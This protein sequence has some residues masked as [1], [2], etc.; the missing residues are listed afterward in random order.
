M[1][2]I[3][4]LVLWPKKLASTCKHFQ[5]HA[6]LQILLVISVVLGG[7]SQQDEAIT[8]VE[9]PP[10]AV[11]VSSVS[12][13]N[14]FHKVSYVGTVHS[15]REVK[16]I[17]QIP[18]TVT[19]L[20]AEGSTI[21]NGQVLARIAARETE[22]RATRV[23]AEAQRATTERDFLCKTFD[24]D[25]R[26][27]AAGVISKTK[28]DLS[29]KACDSANAAL[30][31]ALAAVREARVGTSKTLEAAPF[32]GHVLRWLVESGQNVMP[33]TPLLL[34]G[35]HSLELRVQ[36]AERDISKGVGPGSSALVQVRGN[37]TK[38]SI[39]EVAPM[40]TGPSRSVEVR[41]HFTGDMPASL[42]HGMS[43]RVDLVLAEAADTLAIPES[44]LWTSGGKTSVFLIDGDL[45]RQVPVEPDIRDRGWV[46][47][48]GD[49]SD[50]VFVAV[51]N[52][53]VLKDGIKIF[54]VISRSAGEVQP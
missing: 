36:V 31:A 25:K 5:R 16:V 40:A 34:F 51:S 11:R 46:A 15:R 28:V 26:L 43:A 20:A 48:T 33:G 29:C 19:W 10:V 32:A 24:T 7:C 53:D 3:S 6:G 50:G 14:L 44:A 23:D 35:D 30:K 21:R 22:A 52:L 17:A 39:T 49:V 12:R 47:V 54:P 8:P 41:I 4:K 9:S 38:L 42:G 2:S 1:Q 18:G 45:A 37:S 13:Q 27:G